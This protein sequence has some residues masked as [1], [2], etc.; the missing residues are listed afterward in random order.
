MLFLSQAKITVDAEGDVR[1]E[2]KL[3]PQRANISVF[4]SELELRSVTI[5]YRWGKLLFSKGVP[6]ALQQR[7]RN[8]IFSECLRKVRRI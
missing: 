6:A 1:V 5:R 2:G 4:L 7:I 8:F 3:R